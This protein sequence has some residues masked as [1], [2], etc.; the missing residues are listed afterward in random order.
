MKYS[1][2]P[3]CFVSCCSALSERENLHRV[4]LF[5]TLL[6]QQLLTPPTSQSHDQSAEGA[7]LHYIRSDLEKSYST[8]MSP[9][10]TLQLP[11][12]AKINVDNT[13]SEFEAA[14]FGDMVCEQYV[15]VCML[16]CCDMNMMANVLIAMGVQCLVSKSLRVTARMHPVMMSSQSLSCQTNKVIT[17]SS[18]FCTRI[19][20]Q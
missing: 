10:V 4:N 2:V 14:D 17:Q 12:E 5:F 20:Y 15:H 18:L 9:A 19:F 16:I 3:S 6:S 8:V 1:I 7:V 11:D 13:L